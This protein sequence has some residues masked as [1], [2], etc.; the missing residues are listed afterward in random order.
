MITRKQAQ[1]ALRAFTWCDGEEF[2]TCYE[3]T[4]DHMPRWDGYIETQFDLMNRKP[5]DFIIKWD[6]L[7]AQIVTR[8]VIRHDD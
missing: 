1:N 3:K 5:L 4:Y 8:Y 6:A 2:L 7:A